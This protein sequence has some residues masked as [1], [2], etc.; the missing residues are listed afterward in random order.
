M[1]YILVVD[2]EEKIRKILKIMLTLKGHKVD[3]AEDGKEAL[4]MIKE[5]FYDLVIADIKMKEMSG[6]ELLKEIKKMTPPIPVVFI[7]A[8][9]TIESAVE[10]MKEGAIDY[11]PK[12]FEEDRIHL[13]VERALGISKIIKEKEELKEE[14]ERKL[15]PENIICESKE[16]KHVINL[17]QKVAQKDTTVLI[18]GESGVGKEVIARYLHSLSHRKDKRFIAINCA[19]IPQNLIESELF[20]H[21]RGAFTGAV[22]RKKGIFEA[23]NGGTV[24]L[25]EIGDLPLEA[26]AKLLRVLQEKIIYR[27]GGTEEIKIDVR[28]IAATNQ[29]LE[30]LVKDGKFRE[31]LYYRLNV[32]PIKIPP[33][34]ERKEDIIPLAEYFIRKFLNKNVEGILLTPSAKKILLQYP[35]PGNVREL[36]NAIERAIIISGSSLPLSGE[37]F[38]FLQSANQ[39]DNVFNLPPEGINL[40]EL[41][42]QLIKQALERTGGNQSAAARLLGLT[43]SKFRTRMKMIQKENKKWKRLNF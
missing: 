3:L 1:A 10:A 4:E 39:E 6:I 42:K 33:L 16:M 37:H 23:A 19:A 43:R 28:I 20:G 35:F 7:T 27:L 38:S 5:N 2:D 29:N 12:P 30:E 15:I 32:F 22:K 31:D 8:Y 41:E 24:F 18:T 34:R 13:T 26:Q 21:E 40:E 17:V 14:L 36:A 11:I 25:D 9:A